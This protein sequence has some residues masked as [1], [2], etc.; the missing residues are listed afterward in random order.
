VTPKGYGGSPWGGETSS[1]PKNQ[2]KNLELGRKIEK[3]NKK[4]E[5]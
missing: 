1:D 5:A 3:R 4:D 2:E